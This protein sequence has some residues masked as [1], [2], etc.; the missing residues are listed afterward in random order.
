MTKLDWDKANRAE[1][2]K[3][4]KPK[5]QTQKRQEAVAKAYANGTKREQERI[6]KLLE[7]YGEGMYLAEWE[8]INDAI[9]LIKEGQR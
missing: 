9:A 2:P 8:L 7:N 4:A 5:T 3:V 1:M 6:I